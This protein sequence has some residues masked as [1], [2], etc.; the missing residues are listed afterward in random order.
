[1]AKGHARLLYM[2]YEFNDDPP[3]HGQMTLKELRDI[4]M[5]EIRVRLRSGCGYIYVN[6][7]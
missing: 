6:S 5:I 7:F 3:V 2:K 4:L 1:M